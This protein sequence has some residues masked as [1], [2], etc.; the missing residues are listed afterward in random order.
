MPSG[1]SGVTYNGIKAG[2]IDTIMEK[3]NSILSFL[4][5]V[6]MD[7]PER[8]RN[9]TAVISWLADTRCAILI[10]EADSVSRTPR[11]IREH[12][13]V[14]YIFVRDE[15][16]CFHRTRY[17]NELLSLSQ[18][19]LSAVWDAD[20][21]T[22]LDNIVR[23]A[24]QNIKRGE[25]ITYPY[26]R[27]CIWLSDDESGLFCRSLDIHTI[28]NTD[29][30]P[31]LG[32][33]FCG[34][35]FLVD[36]RRYLSVGGE[37]ERFTGW[38]PEDAERLRRCRILGHQAN[39]IDSGMAYHLSHPRNTNSQYF[40]QEMADNMRREF[41]RVCCTATDVASMKLLNLDN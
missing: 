2:Q 23:A 19:E 28:E 20:I 22:P 17:I 10:L 12:D 29:S 37:N 41:V 24:E 34:G 31:I 1:Y 27:K 11:S 3:L 14:R 6:R 7:S 21:V 13:G 15:N 26:N 18:T 4:I 32:R 16:P 9:L 35:A 39:W 5:P 38:G 8:L 33:P 40:S 25:T 30:L 36:T